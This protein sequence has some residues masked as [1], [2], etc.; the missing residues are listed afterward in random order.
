MK[1]LITLAA[2]LA[3]MMLV[4][5]P[6]LAQID[7]GTG[8]ETESGEIEQKFSVTREGSNDVDQA[9]Q[10]ATEEQAE[11][12]ATPAPPP[13]PP[14]PA[15]SGEVAKAAPPPAPAPPKEEMKMEMKKEEKKELPKTGG[16]GSASLLGL[17]AGVLL[18][19]GGL[20]VRRIVR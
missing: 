9:P 7:Q 4:T 6:A 17:G 19:G 15:A 20:L 10:V 18:I 14:P 1:K 3:T 8:Q 16:S 2:T 11:I 13:P 5:V 12:E